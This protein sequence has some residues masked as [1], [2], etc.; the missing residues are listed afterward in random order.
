MCS[1]LIYD[2]DRIPFVVRGL[3]Q[4]V[5]CAGVLLVGYFISVGIPDGTGFGV[6]Y[7]LVEMGFGLLIW[8]G[9]FSY[10]WHEARLI[11]K[12]L[13]ERNKAEGEG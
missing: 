11:K 9:N 8:I 2:E 5:I 7:F 10:F 4:L 1:S 3:I 6:I 13:A 12:K